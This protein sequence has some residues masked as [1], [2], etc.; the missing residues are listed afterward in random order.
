MIPCNNCLKAS[1]GAP[2]IHCDA[3]RGP[4]HQS[5]AGL[6]DNDMKL[7][8][9]K[10]R[11]VKLLCNNCSDN[12]SKF[13]DFQNL[14]SSLKN[15]L[16]DTLK[17]VTHDVDAKIDKLK[18]DIHRHSSE[19]FELICQEIND[20]QARK[21]NIIIYGAQEQNASLPTNVRKNNE[22]DLI[23]EIISTIAPT[24]PYDITTIHHLRLGRYNTANTRPRPIKI[25]LSNEFQVHSIIKN[26]HNLKKNARLSGISIAFDRTP[27]QQAH[28]KDVRTEL[29]R[30][31]A[32]GENNLIIKYVQGLP[33][34]IQTQSTSNQVNL[35]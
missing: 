28:Y 2:V 16:F 3:C 19:Q 30:R 14:L 15:E 32:S 4:I 23:S 29:Q 25:T 27:K 26:A 13:K 24:V 9:S 1:A 17:K 21:R 22:D 8:R 18:E 34:I 12:I 6:S 31:T 5:C 7:T 33:K 10:S 11:N 35:N 20:R